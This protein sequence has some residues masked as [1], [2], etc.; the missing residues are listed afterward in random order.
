MIDA[1]LHVRKFGDG[2]AVSNGPTFSPD[3]MTLYWSD[4]GTRQC[5]AWDYDP[6]TGS[7]SNRRRHGDFFADTLTD[8]IVV[9]DGATI[10]AEGC[11]W[12]ACFFGQELRRYTPDG[13]LDRRLPLPVNS[14]TS[15]AFGGSDLDIL[16]VT[17]MAMDDFPRN[18]H[19]PG[20]VDGTLLA[21]HGLGVAGVPELRFGG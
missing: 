17:S 11:R 4:S 8:S 5:Y 9:P 2:V 1:D 10:D 16:F 12:V 20:P 21:V 15:V 13:E 18:P 7:A 3:G 19:R 6:K 14:P